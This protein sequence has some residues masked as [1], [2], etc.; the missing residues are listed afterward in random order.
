VSRYKFDANDILVTGYKF[1]ALQWR[2]PDLSPVT[3]L[4]WVQ[5][6][7]PAGRQESKN[8]DK[9]IYFIVRVIASAL[10]FVKV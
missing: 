8:R 7:L 3:K 1:N 5:E 9:F 2:G 10:L 6:H 4:S